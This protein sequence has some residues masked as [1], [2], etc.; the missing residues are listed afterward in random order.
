MKKKMTKMGTGGAA[1][2]IQV[3]SMNEPASVSPTKKGGTYKKG[4]KVKKGK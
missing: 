1:G 3:K 2:K 4:G